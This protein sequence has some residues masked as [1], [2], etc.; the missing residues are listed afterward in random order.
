MQLICLRRPSFTETHAEDSGLSGGQVE[1][2]FWQLKVQHDATID[3]NVDPRALDATV[4]LGVAPPTLSPLSQ[5]VSSAPHRETVTLSY[6][7]VRCAVVCAD[8]DDT[9]TGCRLRDA[10]AQAQV[11]Y[12]LCAVL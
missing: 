6:C 7:I 12:C 11:Q 3:A 9:S 5:P 1:D 10:I 4:C 2:S 8:C